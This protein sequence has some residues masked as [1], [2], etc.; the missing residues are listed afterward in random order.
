VIALNATHYQEE[1]VPLTF[2]PRGGRQGEAAWNGVR[3]HH[4]DAQ[5]LPGSGGCMDDMMCD[6]TNTISMQAISSIS[7]CDTG[8]Q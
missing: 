5:Q 8:C 3:Y 1:E 7:C 2:D 6:K 4:M